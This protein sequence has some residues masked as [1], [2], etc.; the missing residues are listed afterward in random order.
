MY[1]QWFVKGISGTNA[2]SPSNAL[3]RQSAYNLISSGG[4]ILSNWWRKKGTITTSDVEEVLT[5]QNLDRH[6]HDYDK[7][8][9]ES[10]FISLATGCV[11]R[12]ALLRQNQIYSAV[13]TALQFATDD[14]SHP[15]ALFF[16]WTPVGYN[17]AVGFSGASEAVRDLNVYRRWSPYQ[18]E[19]EVTAKINIAANQIQKVEWWDGNYDKRRPKDSFLNPNFMP[20][21]PL[22][23]VREF[24]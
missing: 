16:G 24:F 15:G 8:G 13:D 21:D 18:L 19:G 22:T 17:P 14:W 2:S 6:L 10:P 23:N 11:E 7:Y 9:S 5:D 4:G 3:T 20:P 1:I 12:N